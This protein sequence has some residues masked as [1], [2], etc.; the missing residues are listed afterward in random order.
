[1]QKEIKNKITW[2]NI[3]FFNQGWFRYWL[4]YKGPKWLMRKRIRDQITIRIASMNKECYNSGSCIKCGCSTTA[5]QMCDKACE[6]FCYPS[7]LN[8]RKWKDI[9]G[10]KR[11]IVFDDETQKFWLIKENKFKFLNY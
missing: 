6:G 7:M 2:K 11:K 8:K 3:W 10:P 1:M 5:L 9:S 4:Y